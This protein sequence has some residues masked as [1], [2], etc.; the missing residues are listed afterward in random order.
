[1][2]TFPF[3]QQSPSPH[4]AECAPLYILSKP[5]ATHRIT[6]VTIKKTASFGVGG[7]ISLLKCL[8]R[9]YEELDLMQSAS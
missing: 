3:L 4:P 1:M 9:V 5:V 2:C 8:P 6:K 7:V